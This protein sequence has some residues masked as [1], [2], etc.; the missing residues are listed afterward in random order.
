MNKYITVKPHSG[1]AGIGHQFLNWLV[2]Y[3]LADK[4]NLRFVHQDFVGDTDGTFAPKGS[5]ANQI[6]RPVKEWNSFLNLGVDEFRIC[7]LDLSL[8]NTIEVPYVN[9]EEAVWNHSQFQ[10]LLN[11]DLSTHDKSRTLYKISEHSDGQFIGVDWDFY[12]KNGLKEKYNKSIQVKNFDNYFDEDCLNIAIHIRRGDVTKETPYRR[13]QDLKYYLAIM[14]NIADIKEV[15]NI[16]FHIYSWDMSKEERDILL[17]HE[18][19]GRREVI[20]HIDEDVFSTFYHLTK[21]DIFVSGQGA[22][23]LMANYLGDGIKLTT[24]FYMHWKD[25][26]Q[27]IQDIIEVK[28]DG[29]FDQNKLLK[30][31]EIK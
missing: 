19:F 24:P 6:T 20:L 13:W 14:E 26:P 21:A 30:V 9:Q 2:P 17:L 3:M 31:L 18:C 4:Y 22:F 7:D 1:W 15:R 12:R 5:N 10:T 23:S 8:F 25:F 16:V 28:P 29:S 11:S 27:D